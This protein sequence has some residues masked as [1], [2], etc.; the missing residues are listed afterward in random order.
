MGE[1]VRFPGDLITE[2]DKRRLMDAADASPFDIS[3]RNNE[4]DE[5]VPYLTRC[6][7]MRPFWRLRKG[8][9]GWEAVILTGDEAGQVGGRG[10]T[11]DELMRALI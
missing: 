6:G 4:K 8:G 10:R 5:P 2:H 1:V 11:V 9:C 7:E 3:F